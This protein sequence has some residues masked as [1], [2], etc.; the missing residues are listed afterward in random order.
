MPATFKK[1]STKKAMQ[2]NKYKPTNKLQSYKASK[3]LKKASL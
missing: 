2:K 3:L 1:A